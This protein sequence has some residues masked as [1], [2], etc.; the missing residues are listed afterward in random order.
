[1]SRRK[2]DDEKIETCKQCG[3]QGLRAYWDFELEAYIFMVEESQPFTCLDCRSQN[4][5]IELETEGSHAA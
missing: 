1:M 4:L 2:I 5:I 3:A